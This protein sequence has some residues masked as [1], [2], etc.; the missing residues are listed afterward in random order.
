[1]RKRT[2]ENHKKKDER[3]TRKKG[4]RG[5]MRKRTEGQKED[6]RG[7]HEKENEREP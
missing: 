5:D 1:M 7:R 6:G 3:K 4:L 2:R